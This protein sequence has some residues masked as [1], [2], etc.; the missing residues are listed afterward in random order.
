MPQCFISESDKIVNQQ[1]FRKDGTTIEVHPFKDQ[2][3]S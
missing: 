3:F 1:P 2:Y